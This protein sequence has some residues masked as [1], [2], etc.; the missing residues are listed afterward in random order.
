MNGVLQASLY[1][2]SPNRLHFCGPSASSEI[3]DYIDRKESDLGLSFLLK[4]FEVMFPYLQ[5]IAHSNGIQDPFDEKVVEAYWLGNEFLENISAKIAFRHLKDELKLKKKIGRESFEK[6]ENKILQGARLC[7]CFHVLNI[8]KRMGK[9]N[10]F[11]TL[12]SMDACRISW[13]KILSVDGPFLDVATE[14]LTLASDKLQLGQKIKK[15]IMRR[16]SDDDLLDEAKIGDV[17]SI[18]W[19]LPCEI[20]NERQLQNLKRFTNLSIQL[21]NQI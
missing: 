3:L 14:P 17:I 1:A 11:H 12:E 9:T 21:A 18:H 2:F 16:L 7:H 13:G 20:L 6:I 8:G 4:K 19:D 5:T 10:S 15:R